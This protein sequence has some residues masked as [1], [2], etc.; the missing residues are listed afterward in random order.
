MI[1]S[2]QHVSP[3]VQVVQQLKRDVATWRDLAPVVA[4]LRAPELRE[5]HWCR[6][7]EL[8]G[9]AHLSRGQGI[10]LQA[11]MDLKVGCSWGLGACFIA[12]A[13]VLP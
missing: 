6:A 2:Q 1:C 11:L 4:A 12:T 8:L 13:V 7:E 9:G 10:S 5:R 3:G